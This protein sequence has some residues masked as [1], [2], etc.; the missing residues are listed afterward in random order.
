MLWCIQALFFCYSYFL[1]MTFRYQPSQNMIQCNL[2]FLVPSTLLPWAF[3]LAL[4]ALAGEIASHLLCV[5]G[6]LRFS[7][8][9]SSLRAALSH[10]L[11]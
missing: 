2:S 6:H 4:T 7:V 10:K 11:H 5:S 9:V 3:L 1:D 8:D